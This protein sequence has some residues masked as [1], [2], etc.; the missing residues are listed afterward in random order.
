[1]FFK[2]LVF[3][4]MHLQ[5]QKQG[6]KY[7]LRTTE[8]KK[9]S[10]AKLNLHQSCNNRSRFKLHQSCNNRRRFKLHLIYSHI[11]NCKLHENNNGRSKLRLHQICSHISSNKLHHSCTH[12]N[13]HQHIIEQ[14][15]IYQQN[16][17]K[18]NNKFCMQQRIKH[19]FNI[20]YIKH[21]QIRLQYRQI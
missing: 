7:K 2:R 15:H 14:L 19:W 1:M 8:L 4:N 20:K 9:S 10:K 18:K 5:T 16:H 11:N 17:Q 13:K 3:K 6:S 12:R 21:R